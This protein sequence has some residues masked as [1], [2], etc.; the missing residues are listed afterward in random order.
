[1]EEMYYF[2]ATEKNFS[3][4][5]FTKDD[6]E[7][8]LTLVEMG[9]TKSRLEKSIAELEER[10]RTLKDASDE[11]LLCFDDAGLLLSLGQSLIP[12]GEENATK[13]IDSE[14][15]KNEEKLGE[16]SVELK[17]I[18]SCI[19]EAKGKLRSRYGKELHL[20]E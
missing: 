7:Q 3:S 18:V 5:E 20:G 15:G 4:F 1:M 6:A 12:I 10:T 2:G 16:L 8:L 13:R 11:L 14:V 9:M 17:K 19:Q